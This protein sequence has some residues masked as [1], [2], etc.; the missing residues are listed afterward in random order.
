MPG[1]GLM[2][3]VAYGSQ[4]VILNGNPDFTF[5]YK[6]FKRHSHFSKEN[7]S[8]PLDGP[9]EL[10]WDQPI[11]IR[12]KIPRNADLLS[13]LMF[14]FT[15]PDIYSKYIDGTSPRAANY[16]YE[17]QWVRWLGAHILRNVAFFVGGTKIQEFD[18]EYLIAHALLDYPIDKY[19]NWQRLVGDIDELTSPGIGQY[20]GGIQANAIGGGGNQYPTVFVNPFVPDQNERPSIFGQ[21]IY[22]PL[23]FWFAESASKALPL[24]ALQYHECEIQITLR[25]IQELYSIRDASGFRVKPGYR[26][27][28]PTIPPFY[29]DETG[30][31][32][33]DPTGQ[34][35]SV[36]FENKPVFYP[37]NDQSEEFRNFLTDPSFAP[38]ALNNFYYNGYLQGT[39]IY[40]TDEERKVFSTTPLNY[41]ITQQ[42]TIEYDNIYTRTLLD[43][44]ITNPVTRLILLPRRSDQIPYRNAVENYTNWAFYPNEPNNYQG[45]RQV[46][47]WIN[48]E[49][50]NTP[51]P[52]TSNYPNYIAAKNYLDRLQFGGS[53]VVVPNSQRQILQSLRILLDGNEVQEEKPIEFFT[54]VTPYTTLKGGSQNEVQYIP[55]VN[56]A[57]TGPDDQP[58]GSVNAS[59]IRLF[60]LDVNPFPLPVNP[61]Y[62]INLKVIAET[63]NFFTIEGGMGGLKYAL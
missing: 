17:Y 62:T 39:Y 33:L 25:S 4:N 10:F 54:K 53:G 40:L 21:Q 1:G 14:V 51:S 45:L 46:M 23:P 61:T 50:K 7:I 41:L 52:G 9:N 63:Y 35:Q 8:I 59:R 12:A 31:H 6:V 43:L 20:S 44:Q 5:F 57:L 38:P 26:A 2:S 60:Q 47:Y 29:N 13:D 19:N 18:G 15:I 37:S 30:K 55:V 28:M 24:V 58:S 42:T 56:F 11:K 16:Q 3:L 48:I 27:D 32:Y 49:Y 22:V 34:L 36:V